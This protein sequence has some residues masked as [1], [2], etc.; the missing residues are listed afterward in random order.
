MFID[1]NSIIIASKAGLFFAHISRHL[2]FI[3]TLIINWDTWIE[4]HLFPCSFL[5]AALTNEWLF[6]LI[7]HPSL[8]RAVLSSVETTENE[9]GCDK[10]NKPKCVLTTTGFLGSFRG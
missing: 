1:I 5:L 3:K 4:S 10:V 9:P 7:R 2:F 6:E 8:I